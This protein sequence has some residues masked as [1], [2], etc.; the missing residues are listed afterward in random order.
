MQPV[1]VI[2]CREETTARVDVLRRQPHAGRWERLGTASRSGR[3]A[4]R[5][6]TRANA[7]VGRDGRRKFADNGRF[8]ALW[9]DDG[10]LT[11]PEFD[12]RSD[13]GESAHHLDAHARAI[14]IQQQAGTT[15][16]AAKAI[17]RQCR[18]NPPWPPSLSRR[19][20]GAHMGGGG[21]TAGQWHPSYST[22]WPPS[23]SWLFSWV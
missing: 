1:P 18:C 3:R 5:T 12:H 22:T 19:R 4:P 16:A 7:C 6:R 20:A 17:N 15:P 13:H 2:P 14:Q 9:M 21:R 10:S 23:T 11:D 8:D